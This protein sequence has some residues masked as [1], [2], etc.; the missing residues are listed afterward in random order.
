MES[1][2][3]M[4]EEWKWSV[5]CDPLEHFLTANVA[6]WFGMFA[7]ATAMLAAWKL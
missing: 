7:G 6:F 5:Y 4:W 2:K 3:E 1:L